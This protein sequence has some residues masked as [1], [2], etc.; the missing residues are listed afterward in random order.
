MSGNLCWWVC[1]KSPFI[2][3]KIYRHD[4]GFKMFSVLTLYKLDQIPYRTRSVV[5]IWSMLRVCSTYVV[6]CV[7]LVY[8]WYVMFWYTYYQILH[9]VTPP[10]TIK[11]Q[12]KKSWLHVEVSVII[13]NCSFWVWVGYVRF[14]LDKMGCFYVFYVTVWLEDNIHF[15]TRVSRIICRNNCAT[16]ILRNRCCQPS[17]PPS[18]TLLLPHFLPSS[19]LLP[20]FTLILTHPPSLL[21]LV[22]LSLSSTQTTEWSSPS[23][24]TC[25]GNFH[26]Y[27]NLL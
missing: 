19:S 16:D 1:W 27:S 3:Y 20:R 26:A 15:R 13:Q 22:I 12:V 14:V 18:M 4:L 5:R 6:V 2:I 23:C 7:I 10:E 17:L 9:D 8:S 24:W 11:G 21:P 25:T